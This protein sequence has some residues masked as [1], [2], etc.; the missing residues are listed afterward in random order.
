MRRKH[1]TQNVF[2]MYT[3]FTWNICVKCLMDFRREYGW[4]TII[5]SRYG[6]PIHVCGQCADTRAKAEAIFNEFKKISFDNRPP[7]PPSPPPKRI[8]KHG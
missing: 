1:Y 7:P 8:I 5:G 6:F 2:K 4:K 3:L